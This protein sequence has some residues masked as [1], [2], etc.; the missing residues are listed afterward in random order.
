[1][2]MN[3]INSRNVVRDLMDD[4]DESLHMTS[5]IICRSPIQAN[6]KQ[7]ITRIQKFDLQD[8]TNR[9]L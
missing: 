1:M 3:L 7:E 6:K 5:L 8:E 9:S 4:T 2:N